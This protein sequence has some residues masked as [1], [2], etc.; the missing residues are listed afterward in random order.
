[1]KV[2]ALACAIVALAVV[3]GS[4]GGGNDQQASDPAPS[5][6]APTPAAE[7]PP[8]GAIG[9]SDVASGEWPLTVSDGVVRCEGSGGIGSVIFTAPDG[10]DYAVNGTAKGFHREL[11]EIDAIW[12]KPDRYGL[13]IDMS[14]IIDKGLE[15]C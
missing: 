14:P 2:V 7:S 10:T 6:A 11:P 13:R 3:I 12:K 4:V 9:H 8:D 1:M 15:L 5:S